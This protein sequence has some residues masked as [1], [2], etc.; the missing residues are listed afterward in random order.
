[1]SC[2]R[3]TDQSSGTRMCT[4]TKA[5]LPAARVRTAWNWTS[6][7][8]KPRK[9]A[10]TRARSPSGSARSI[11]PPTKRRT[12]ETAVAT[13]LAATRSAMIGSSRSQPVIATAATPTT[14]PTD[15]LE[16]LG[17]DQPADG[18]VGD[19]HRRD[20]DQR[21]PRPRRQGN[22]PSRAIGMLLVRRP[23]GPLQDHKA[24]NRSNQIDDG[25]RGVRQQAHRSRQRPRTVADRVGG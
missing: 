19:R 8:V 21:A 10:S 14:T 9:T 17:V 12:S 3:L 13:M 15:V 11:R 6:S 22:R 4:D 7:F 24:E 20:E 18:G 23:L 5:R 2:P 25:L 16:S 1:M